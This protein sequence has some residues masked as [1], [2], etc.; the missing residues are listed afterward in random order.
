M[1][2]EAELKEIYTE[3]AELVDVDSLYT[4]INKLKPLKMKYILQYIKLNKCKL[5]E[6]LE[7]LKAQEGKVFKSITET[8]EYL[9]KI[10]KDYEGGSFVAKAILSNYKFLPIPKLK[11]V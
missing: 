1:S 7:Y 3:I 6:V 8:A 5:P 9:D 4:K 2:S 11:G 10:K